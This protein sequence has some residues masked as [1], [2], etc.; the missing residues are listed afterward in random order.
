MHPFHVSVSRRSTVTHRWPEVSDKIQKNFGGGGESGTFPP[1]PGI[2]RLLFGTDG[3]GRADTA[4][5]P[6]D[7]G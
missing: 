4:F 5:Y 2:C 1:E 6:I 7:S 3:A